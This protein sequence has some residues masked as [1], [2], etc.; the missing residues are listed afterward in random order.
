MG[1]SQLTKQNLKQFIFIGGGLAAGL[2]ALRL[3][4]THKDIAITI[5]EKG[6]RVGGEHTW[7]FHGSDLEYS[8]SHH[9]NQWLQPLI[10]KSWDTYDVFFPQFHRRLPGT[11]HS[12]RSELFAKHIEQASNINIISKAKAL[13]FDTTSVRLASGES[14]NADFV[15]DSRGFQT[16]DLKGHGFQKFIGRFIRTKTPHRFTRPVLMDSRVAQTDG[17]RFIYILP[18]SETQLLVEDTRYA[19]TPDLNEPVIEQGI[20]NYCKAMGIEVA[21]VIGHERGSLPLPLTAATQPSTTSVGIAKIGAAA[22]NFNAATGYSVVE[23]IRFA[24][25]LGA[26]SRFDGQLTAEIK[27]YNRDVWSRNQYARKLNSMLFVASAPQNRIAIM[28]RFYRHSPGLIQRFYSGQLT[29]T[30][31]LRILAIRPPVA[32]TRALPAFL[33]P[34]EVRT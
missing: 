33:L 31:K 32:L 3:T 19:D 9:H 25:W 27:K 28:S 17:Y 34:Q 8:I 10:A 15:F 1:P 12:I 29:G 11:Y 26:K 21:E 5:I 6:E 14:L 7:C 18:F 20:L 22:G 24:N 4:S 16:Y 2:A 23:S 30:D 13:S